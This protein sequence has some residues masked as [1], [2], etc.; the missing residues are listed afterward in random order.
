MKTFNSNHLADR[1]VYLS[2][3]GMTCAS[4]AGRVEKALNK[5][6]GVQQ[7]SVN[8]ATESALIRSD[9]S[10]DTDLLIREVAATGYRASVKP[11]W[12]ASK[13]KSQDGLTVVMSALLSLPLLA[14]MLLEPFGTQVSLPGW[15]QLGLATPVQ[16]V[17]GARFYRVGWKALKAGAGN[18]DLLVALGTSAA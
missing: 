11:E 8:L 16:F 3:E 7:A 18:M 13:P 17:L 4:C 12:P 14:P 15:L 6:P 9:G 1:T 2:I 10:V 5:I